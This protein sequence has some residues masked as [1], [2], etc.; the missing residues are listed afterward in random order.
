MTT[1]KSFQGDLS[2]LW[3]LQELEPLHHLTWDWWWW[4]LM[5]DDEDDKG[6]SPGRQLMVLWSTKDNAL[7]EV[8]GFP[9]QPNGRPGFDENGAI[10]MDG[11]I[12]AWW[13]DGEKM[14]EPLLLEESRI[15]VISEDHPSW[16][17]SS[18]GIVAS[19]TEREYSMGL[20]PEHTEFWLRLET[21]HG[22]FN[23]K[24]KPWNLPMST[25]K[26]AL[27]EYGGGMGYGISRLHGAL[28][29]GA[30]DGIETKG[31]AYFQKVCVQAPSPPWFWGMLHF[32]DGSYLDWF[33]PHIS[34][35]ITA[36]DSRPWKKRDIT[37]LALSMG[38]LFHDVSRKR[39]ER[40]SKVTVERT[41]QENELPV[42]H[43]HMWNGITEIRIEAKAVSRAHWTFDQPT[44]GGMTSHLTYNEYPLEIVNIEIDDEISVRSRTDWS[45]IR[46]NAEHSWGLLH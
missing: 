22:D 40:F 32:D 31:T 43:V 15:I 23:F 35:T 20:N 21:K 41:C 19:M 29:E 16:P 7:V 11:M 30:I 6:N 46:G 44:R 10:A 8:N 45:Q 5:L 1:I 34:P 37:H 4:L 25:M 38:G 9:W 18:G 28:C 26:K 33:V 39:T 14:L 13:F 3:K 36:R 12:A 42:F 2:S 17:H 27:A 24:M